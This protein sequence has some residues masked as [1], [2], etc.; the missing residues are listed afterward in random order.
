VTSLPDVSI[1]VPCYNEGHRLDVTLDTLASWFATPPEIILVDDGSTDDTLERARGRAASST[2]V[3]VHPLSRNRGKGAAIREAIALATAPRVVIVDA[4]LAFDRD[5]VLAVI[6]ALEHSDMA[7]GNRRH[8]DSQYSVPVRLFGFLYRRHLVGLAFNALVRSLF[9][10][11]SRDTQCGLK[12][13]RRDA[14]RRVGASL[15]IDGF[16][17]DVEM[18]L[19]ARALGLRIT[20]VPVRV[21]YLS[22]LSSVRLLGN[23][24]A[25]VRDLLTILARRAGGRYA[26]ARVTRSGDETGMPGPHPQA[27]GSSPRRTP[28]EKN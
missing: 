25:V 7:V 20:D 13:F 12:G 28:A 3:R 16:A 23:A 15:S 5:S 9:P 14:L 1:I 11:R 19:V 8:H 27:T 17:A 22:A 4:D 2:H 24:A 26:P 10:V 6:E 21:T 18:I